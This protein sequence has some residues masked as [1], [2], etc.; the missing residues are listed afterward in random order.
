[1]S[2]LSGLFQQGCAKFALEPIEAVGINEVHKTNRPSRNG[3]N[4]KETGKPV[5]QS[6]DYKSAV[7]ALLISGPRFRRSEL[8]FFWS[9]R[10][11]LNLRP[12]RPERSALPGCAT[13]RP[14]E[15]HGKEA[16]VSYI[17]GSKRKP[18]ASATPRQVTFP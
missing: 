15:T 6:S 14:G 2:R 7:A 8:N 18:C 1:M 17:R 10:K 9:G 3:L 13:P 12:L 4:S 16:R 11:D 5:A